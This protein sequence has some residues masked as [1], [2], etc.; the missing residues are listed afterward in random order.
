[1]WTGSGA[2]L[3]SS[4]VG[5]MLALHGPAQRSPF[6]S[7]NRCT[8]VG[9]AVP[10]MPLA[11]LRRQPEQCL[12][13]PYAPVS[14]AVETQRSFVSVTLWSRRATVT[15]WLV[16]RASTGAEASYSWRT[17]PDAQSGIRSVGELR[18]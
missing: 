3:S 4:F 7:A 9:E 18:A 6:V 10:L 2:P 15:W 11:A 8:D 1:M 5:A 14:V 12:A 17:S 16:G 13:R